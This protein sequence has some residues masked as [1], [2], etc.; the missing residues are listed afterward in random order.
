MPQI[1]AEQH[2]SFIV[3]GASDSM[4]RMGTF[5]MTNTNNM[6]W[7][8]GKFVPVAG[9]GSD[10]ITLSGTSY[11]APLV[12]GLVAYYRG[13]RYDEGGANMF[14]DPAVVKTWLKALSRTVEVGMLV[15]EEEP[16]I[17]GSNKFSHLV[18]TVW[19]GQLDGTLSCVLDGACSG[20][21]I[22]KKRRG[23][24]ERRQSGDSCP[25]PLLPGEEAGAGG[26]DGSG[27]GNGDGTINDGGLNDQLGPT[28][29]FTYSSGTP[30]PTCT[31]NCG[32][33]CTDFWCR[34]DRTGQPDHFTEPTRISA[35]AIPPSLPTGTTTPGNGGTAIPPILPTISDNEGTAIPPTL[36]TTTTSGD[37]GAVGG[38]TTGHPVVT[39]ISTGPPPPLSTVPWLTNCISTAIWT[40][41]AIPNAGNTV[42][43]ATSSCA[44]TATPTPPPSL[45]STHRWIAIHL[46]ELTIPSGSGPTSWWRYWSVHEDPSTAEALGRYTGF[47]NGD[48]VFEKTDSAMTIGNDDYPNDLGWFTAREA[49]SVQERG[50]DGAWDAGV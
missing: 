40:R 26:G 36:P 38:G 6:I 8:P 44:A 34:P 2:S 4:S 41:C 33:Y 20:T 46:V 39:D 24:L 37:D 10:L 5:T 16:Y 15:Q 27:N 43:V 9:P 42:C 45:P 21:G 13:L 18:P 48:A 23:F 49:V 3:V 12:A 31:A 22:R 7:A 32:K 1:L 28:K 25:L 35:T 11:A 17:S 29:T 47:C 30:S 50:Q 14:N 19:N